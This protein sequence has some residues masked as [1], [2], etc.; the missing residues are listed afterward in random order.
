MAFRSCP[1]IDGLCLNINGRVDTG[2]RVLTLCC[3]NIEEKPGI[4]FADTPEETLERFLGMRSIT[5]AESVSGV[6]DGAYTSGCAKCANYRSGE[7]SLGLFISYV[8]LSMYPAPC[9]CRC[10]YCEAPKF[11]RD[12]P[13]V[14]AAYEKLFALLELGRETGMIQPNATWQVSTGEITIHPYRERIMK[15]VAGQRAVFFTNAFR[16]DE[17]I[18][19]NLHDNPGSAINLS[20]DAGTSE[21]WK[22]VKGFDNFEE[23]TSNLVQYYKRSARAG[24]ITL[25]YIV[26]PG[27]NDNYEDYA[28]LMEIIKILEVKHLT[29]SRDTGKKYSLSGRERTDLL[30]AAAYLLAMCHKNGVEFDMFTY[31]AEEQKEAV[32]LANEILRKGMV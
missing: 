21:T 1:M 22:K 2:E 12:T 31:T 24:Q 4:A 18:A 11:W 3:E 8:N 25:K 19:Q 32:E 27:I 26:L 29:L 20:I 16:F 15:L 17:D 30:G 10:C 9:Q 14:H 28:S 7:H 5:L 6:R 13:E 23:V